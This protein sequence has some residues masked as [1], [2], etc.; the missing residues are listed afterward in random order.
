MRFFGGLR[1]RW[2]KFPGNDPIFCPGN[3]SPQKNTLF[4]HRKFDGFDFFVYLPL[5]KPNELTWK[6]ES[7]YFGT[8]MVV[9]HDSIPIR[10]SRFFA[11]PSCSKFS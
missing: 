9:A 8:G 5:F 7:D 6:H 4:S 11:A 10:V 3:H 1:N 2:P